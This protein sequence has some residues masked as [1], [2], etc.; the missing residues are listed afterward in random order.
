M[1]SKKNNDFTSHFSNLQ[2]F[3]KDFSARR[4]Q[5][6]DKLI[7]YIL[8]LQTIESE[9]YKVLYEARKFYK[10]QRY[11]CNLKIKKLKR[12]KIEIEQIWSY[13]MEEPILDCEIS[14]SI[15]QT[16]HSIEELEYGINNLNS[17]LEES[18]L[19]I[20]EE[21]EIIEKLRELEEIQQHKIRRVIELEERLSKKLQNS[22]YY[23]NQ[24]SITILEVKLK[25]LYNSLDKLTAKRLNSHKKMLELYRKA[26]EFENIK[27]NIE[28]ELIMNQ[29]AA[30]RNYQLFTQLMNQNKL[31]LLEEL[32]HQ[33]KE[34]I[35]PKE[36]VTTR[37]KSII[38]KKKSHKKLVQERLSLALYKQKS[39]KKLDFYELKLILDHSKK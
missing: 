7:N 30:Y 17:I 38:E 16:K 21:I 29:N 28:K 23:K 13:L 9:I 6:N 36:I 35:Q 39:G 8:S 3:V 19:D 34:E 2:S 11:Y 37:V 18:I 12:K 5:L 32:S 15:E 33:P 22:A 25:E 27:K 10:K 14:Y 20:D 1:S 26:R 24:R 31:V 4:D